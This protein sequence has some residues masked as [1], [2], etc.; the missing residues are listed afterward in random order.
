[1]KKNLVFLGAP[2]AGKGTIA[3]LLIKDAPLTHI[4]TGDIFRSEIKNQTELGK[5]AK[6]FIDSGAL[7]PDE[8]VVD[9]VVSRLQCK[10][11][12]NGFILDGFP[13]TVPQAELLDQAL[14][15]MNKPLD[16]I[17]FFNAKDEVLLERLTARITCKDCGVNFNKLFSPPKQDG[18]CDMC[19]GSLYQR[20]DDSLETAENRLVVYKEQTEPVI[21]YYQ[22]DILKEIDAEPATDINYAAL[23]KVIGL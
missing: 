21:D 10:D 14:S 16:A 19:N 12:D 18:I 22:G 17:I 20:S 5:K 2:G 11:C 4:S 13:R 3:A 6:S 7:V 8:L 9:M 23:K 1:M 15:K